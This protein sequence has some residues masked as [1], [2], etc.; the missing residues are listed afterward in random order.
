MDTFKMVEMTNEELLSVEGGGPY[1]W[2]IE[3]R[4]FFLNSFNDLVQGIRDGWNSTRTP[5]GQ[6]KN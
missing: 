3:V 6:V 2:Y 5:V 4:D 1:Q